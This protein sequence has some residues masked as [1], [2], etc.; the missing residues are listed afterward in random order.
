MSQTVVFIHGGWVT[1]AC[2]D[3]FVSYFEARGY[4]CLAP[5][6]PGKD[7]LGRGHPV[8][9]VGAGRPRHRRD[10]RPLRA[11][12]PRARRAADPRRPLVRRALRPAAPRPRAR[13]GRH[14][15][16]LGPAEG[17]LRLRAD[18][19]P[20]A[21]PD[22]PHP[23]RLA[24]GRPLEL[25]RVSLRLRPHDAARR[26]AGDLGCPDRARLGPPLLRERVLDARSR[27]PGAGR[28]REPGSSA[29]PAS[30]P[31]RRTG[32]CRRPSS[33]GCSAPTRPRPPGRTSARSPAGPTGSSPRTAGR[34][35]PRPASTGSGRL[36]GNRPAPT[37]TDDQRRP[38]A[39]ALTRSR[40]GGAGFRE[41]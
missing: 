2:W 19:A 24:E 41:P 14:R 20:V 12:R 30:S 18:D 7:R 6:W 22:P 36:T 16:R 1:P 35:S 13:G 11:D 21:G 40:P 39:G 8:R 26:A 5:A 31:G 9:S 23:V 38:G 25:P 15:D 29:P 33:G 28:L 32:R 17:R 27:E 3:P 37:P 34:R 10:R 4:R